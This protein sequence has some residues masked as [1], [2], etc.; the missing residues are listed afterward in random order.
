MCKQTG[1]EIDVY[2][3]RLCFR[4][5]EEWIMSQVRELELPT[6]GTLTDITV[7]YH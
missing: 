3:Y 1:G 7:D 2:I 6:L 4:D 5:K